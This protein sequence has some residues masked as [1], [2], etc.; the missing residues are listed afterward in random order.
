MNRGEHIMAK[1]ESVHN[2]AISRFVTIY[3][4]KSHLLQAFVCGKG[5]TKVIDPVKPYFTYA[6]S[7]LFVLNY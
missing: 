5:L 4:F 6:T 1:E 7:D 3:V 2:W